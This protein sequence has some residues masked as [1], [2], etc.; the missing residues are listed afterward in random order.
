MGARGRGHA[1]PFLLAIFALASTACYVGPDGRVSETGDE[2]LSGADSS[3]PDTGIDSGGGD[4]DTGD[5]PAPQLKPAP[6]SLRLLLARQYENSIRDLL[7]PAAAAVVTPPDDA[8]I[9]GLEAIAA[10][11]LAL[12]DASV[13]AYESSARAAAAA[14]IQNPAGLQAHL[15]CAPTGPSDAAC[16]EQFVRSFGRVA[17]RRALTQEE[18]E[19]YVSVAQTAALEADDFWTGIE[20]AIATFLQS[21]FFLYQVELGT[22]EPDDPS[23]RRLRGVELATRM[24]FFLL[25]TTPSPELLDEA[26]GGALDT[27]EGVRAVARALL[28]D[29]DARVALSNFYA[30]ILRLRDLESLPKDAGIYPSWSPELAAALRVETLTLIEDVIWQQDG[31]VRDILDAPYTFVNDTLASFYGLSHPTGGSFAPDHFL[32]VPLPASEKRGG[33]FGQGAYLAAFSH[34]SSTSPT[35]R[36]KFVREA[37]MCQT[38]PAPPPDVETVLPDTTEDTPTMR[39]RLEIHMS[40]PACASCHVA[41][42]GIGFGLENY[43]GVGLFRTTENGATIN[44]VSLLDPYGEFDGAR[45]L[46]AL[47]REAPEVSLCMVRNIFRHAT[48]HV[49]VIGEL[50]TLQ[51]IDDRFAADGFHMQDLLVELV[52]SDAFRMV[53]AAE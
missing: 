22:P 19:L 9:N 5:E 21:P 46:G 47:L 6:A 11:Q 25:D 42:D 28:L 52:A 45:E 24:S 3:D 37:L 17:W 43:D 23:V 39:D 10:A 36:G 12:S 27:P 4:D 31:D 16:H 7:G 26:E 35:L 32:K 13:D 50:P 8:Q 44:S 38:I 18:V 34:I 51:E 30:E 48:G 40:D 14:A 20:Y 41:M 29:D 15:A 53:G 2:G 49:E 1:A 33:I